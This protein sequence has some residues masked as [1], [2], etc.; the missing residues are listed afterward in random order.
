MHTPCNLYLAVVH[1]IIRYLKGTSQGGVFFPIETSFN[2]FGY[3]D[4][5]WV[6]YPDT[7]RFTTSWCTFRSPRH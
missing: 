3:S 1:C 5:D 2:L 4:V 6:G 7:K